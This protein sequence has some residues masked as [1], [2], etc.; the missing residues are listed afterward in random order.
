MQVVVLVASEVQQN[1]AVWTFRGNDIR[2]VRKARIVRVEL[3]GKMNE[4]T[5]MF[6]NSYI[7]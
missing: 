6:H 7:S 1:V 2:F 4:L 5:A 3:L